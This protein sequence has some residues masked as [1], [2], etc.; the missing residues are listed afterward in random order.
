MSHP[1]ALNV[2]KR[3]IAWADLI[4]E[5][6]TPGTMEKWGLGWAELSA[7]ADAPVERYAYA[8]VGYH[9][10]LDGTLLGAAQTLDDLEVMN[11]YMV[12]HPR[13]PFANTLRVQRCHADR[14]WRCAE[15]VHV[16]RGHRFGF[17]EQTKPQQRRAFGRRG[18]PERSSP[19]SATWS[20]S[21]ACTAT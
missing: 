15:P 14:R 2:V 4:T 19:G 13:S 3:F 1:Q 5:N 20:G 6:F 21:S 18:G 17:A 12:T 9:R 8:R 7:L 16:F 11:H 10:G